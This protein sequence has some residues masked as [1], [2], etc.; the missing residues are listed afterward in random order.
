MSNPLVGAVYQQIITDVVE[1]SRVDFEE[2][3]VEESVLEELAMVSFGFLSTLMR[4]D[5]RDSC[6]SKLYA[7]I[8][9]L[10][11]S[12]LPL[13]LSPVFDR[14]WPI[15]SRCFVALRC[16]SAAAATRNQKLGGA[17]LCICLPFYHCTAIF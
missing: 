16:R 15:L 5:G 6:T 9:Q 11:F 17:P 7:M 10:L 3:G 1:T 12:P 14:Y 8:K 2:G 4:I 13:S